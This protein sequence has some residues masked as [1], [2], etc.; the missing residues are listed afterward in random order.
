MASSSD[1]QLLRFWCSSCGTKLTVEPSLAGV[2]GPCP[3]CGERIKAPQLNPEPEEESKSVRKPEIPASKKQ[4]PQ[5]TYKKIGEDGARPRQKKRKS[6]SEQS[7]HISA[8]GSYF[9][10]GNEQ[11]SLADLG[12]I[13]LSVA[14]VGILV[15]LIV[16]W[17]NSQ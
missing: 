10:D 2:E 3:K 14:A 8:S 9:P 16:W 6:R 13:L 11:D 5:K 15:V 4:P 7:R 1:D 12:K 17:V